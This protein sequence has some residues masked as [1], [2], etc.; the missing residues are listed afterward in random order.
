MN[1]T[2]HNIVVVGAGPVGLF[3]AL[4]L[5]HLGVECTLLEAG[6]A[7]ATDLRASTFHPPT[8]EL[9]DEYDVTSKLIEQGRI[10]PT[11][12]VRLHPSHDY[13]EFDLS[14]LKDET[15]HP[16]RV[17]CEQDKLCEILLEKL[18]ARQNVD[19]RFGV[20]VT[21]H[22]QDDDCVT[23]QTE[24]ADG[25][26]TLRAKMLVGA[27]G[28]KS[29]VRKGL[30]IAFEGSTYP[31]TT[32]L[33]TTTFPFEDHLPGLSGIN[34]CWKPDGT[35]SLLRL[36]NLWRCS[37]YPDADESVEDA[38][39]PDAIERKLQAIVPRDER[40]E[41]DN[42]RP[43]RIHMRIVEAY[44]HGRVVL[45]GDAAHLNS[46][47]GGMGMN[48][49]LQD[50]YLLAGALYEIDN[51]GDLSL[52]SRYT[53]QRRPVAFEQILKQADG[54]RK[55]MQE[56]DPSKRQSILDGLREIANDAERCRTHLMNTSMISGWRRSM[57]V[58]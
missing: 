42:V 55:R 52:L 23:I 7:L 31:E 54:N 17:Q 49:G 8:L 28:A 20:R 41:I 50:A 39:H 11:W 24:S 45:A 3:T 25:E 27:D 18:K 26:E 30:D 14:I 58:T 10:C 44:D 57:A 53:R 16:Y 15:R 2:E 51:G 29:A 21:G 56:R 40:Y 43:Y 33:T 19:I 35:F 4:R 22:V 46:P 1:Q 12:Q 9:L 38:V 37:L 34:Y 47:S 13:V 48:G 6:E 32:I 36:P 5:S